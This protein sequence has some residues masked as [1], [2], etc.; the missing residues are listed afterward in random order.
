VV[1]GDEVVIAPGDYSDTAGDLGPSGYVD[2]VANNIHG[3]SGQPRPV[4]TLDSDS[5]FGAFKAETGNVISHLQIDTS[6]SATNVA[7]AGG[8]VRDLIAHSSTNAAIPCRFTGSAT[9]TDSA[10]ISTGEQTRTVGSFFVGA[11]TYTVTLRNVTAIGAGPFISNATGIDF[12]ATDT[13]TLTVDAKSVIALGNTVDVYGEEYLS[14]NVTITLDH[15]NFDGFGSQ[16]S[17]TISSPFANNNQIAAP[18]LASDSIHQLPNSPTVN[19][20]VTDGSSGANDIDSQSRSIGGTP[21]IGADELGHQTTTAVSCAPTSVT[22]GSPTTCTGT[23]TD[24]EVTGA[25]TPT[26]SL[27]FSSDTAGG[28][29]SSGGTCALLTVSSTSAGCSVTYTP[30]QFGSGVHHVTGVYGAD[31]THDLSQGSSSLGIDAFLPSPPP[32]RFQPPT[33]VDQCSA[34]RQK[35]KKAKRAHNA[36][37][38]RKLKKKLRKLGC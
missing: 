22:V 34:L 9:L 25:S 7:L 36:P 8:T 4:I 38:V 19:A 5:G 15:S 28:S 23:V 35:L 10:C 2:T 18:V 1:S 12:A 6:A 11:A 33:A 29:F 17:P 30:G 13:V 14:A 20:G 26:G 24:T 37:L 27:G 16:G 21:D 32:P 31:T 3:A